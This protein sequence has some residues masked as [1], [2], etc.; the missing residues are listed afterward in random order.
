MTRSRLI[1]VSSLAVVAAGVAVALGSRVME[2]A[3]A[4]V[5]PLPPDGLA[6]LS[7]A[8]FVMGLDVKRFVASPFHKRFREGRPDAFK[9]VEAKTGVDPERDVD[10]VFV[11]GGASG[12]RRGVALVQ[13]FFDRTRITR[14]IESQGKS[15][16]WKTHHG[17]TVYLF[18]ETSKSPGAL[19]FLDDRSILLGSAP[20]V[21]SVLARRAEGSAEPASGL[22]VDL[23]ER[24]RSGSTFW[25]VG[26]QSL[27]ASL[28]Q[29]LPGSG[30]GGPP[31]FSLPAVKSLVVTGDLDPQVSLSL[32][33]DTAD[34][35]SAKNVADIVRGFVALASLQA[36]Q[37]P[38]LAQ[39]ASGVSV[40]TE[41][42]RIHVEARLPYELLETLH[43]SPKP[44]A[45]P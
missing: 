8:R 13:G 15:V 12:D 31:A 28:P 34:A 24:V 11:A 38:E 19:A 5:G 6:L 30:A 2:P 35:A 44:S 4:A 25:M 39:L 21:E 37:R 26:D 36:S 33:G 17:T 10:H 41:T 27:L 1:L 45:R 43:G 14:S 3:R 32:T 20:A 22:L 18:G 9:E 7:D 23:L 16:T 40:T 42:N 29:T